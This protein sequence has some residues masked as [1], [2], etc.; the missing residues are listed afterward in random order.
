[1]E[2]EAP[3]GTASAGVLSGAPAV[4]AER[5]SFGP[6]GGSGPVPIDR[7]SFT[8]EPGETL[9][10]AGPSGTGK[11]M[12]LSLVA[13]LGS[14]YSDPQVG[15]HLVVA[16]PEGVDPGP[17][18]RPRPGRVGF[19]QQEPGDGLLGVDLLSALALPL[20]L[21]GLGRDETADRVGHALETSG[22]MEMAEREVSTLSVGERK[23]A[24]LAGIE[25]LDPPLVLL[26]EPLADLDPPGVRHLLDDLA[27]IHTARTVLVA[28]HRIGP[29]RALADRELHLVPSAA[30]PPPR[31]WTPA[32]ARGPGGAEP[33]VV[34]NSLSID[35][36]GRRLID[37]ATFRLGP[38][39]WGLLGRN[40]AGKSTLL[41]VLAGLVAPTSG[42]VTVAGRP[43]WSRGLRVSRR[44]T[45]EVGLRRTLQVCFQEPREAFFA[46]SVKE[47]LTA[48][49]E[50]LGLLLGHRAR[51]KV[52]NG[53]EQAGLTHLAEVSP[54]RL[55]GGEARRVQT[56]G[57][58]LVSPSVLFLDEPTHGL[59]PVA[60]D[61]LR[62][63][64]AAFGRAGGVVIVATHEPAF[65]PAGAEW[66]HLPG[67]GRVMVGD[68]ARPGE[69]GPA[70]DG[71][72]VPDPLAPETTAL[73]EVRP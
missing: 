10:V 70:K 58:L 3:D 16:W 73:P 39:V 18:P 57:A 19:L 25:A 24:A 40:G 22:L 2:A 8:V 60:R 34:A 62:A 9:L 42:A 32:I 45:H 15:G 37:D 29:L 69:P 28:E 21:L 48:P 64:I 23:R 11:S 6:S 33:A 17:L 27:R 30:R 46:A 1:M 67:D 13:G 71:Y 43:V 55:S 47:E 59:D 52:E 54:Q 63:N 31:I 12:L 26:D 38:G 50:R 7:L 51:S 5:L 53:L 66:I 65:L 56:L 14:T 41:S 44:E 35:R 20:E 61:A 72:V 68:A 49:I 4:R 36:G